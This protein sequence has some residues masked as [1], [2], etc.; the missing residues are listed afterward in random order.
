[1]S[2]LTADR[3]SDNAIATAK[4][5]AS[6]IEENF[7]T[8]GGAGISCVDCELMMDSC[9]ISGNESPQ[10]PGAGIFVNGASKVLAKDLSV[11][12][13]SG[14]I[15][16]GLFVKGDK[17][18]IELINAEFLD[19]VASADTCSQV[20]IEGTKTPSESLDEVRCV[21][22]GCTF[23]FTEES[24]EEEMYEDYDEEYKKKPTREGVCFANTSVEFVQSV[25]LNCGV[26]SF[27]A[28]F[29]MDECEFDP[30]P[31][32]DQGPITCVNSDGWFDREQI[33]Q[34]D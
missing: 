11:E 16:A 7:S 19:N 17:A 27:N 31:S 2:S 10:G 20:T 1:M 3:E 25:F 28:K 32:D 33:C 15:G 5:V 4:L 12:S 34:A 24:E 6:R 30:V 14:S 8:K 29:T 26:T 21:F 18:E 13:N 9:V 23:G 22:M